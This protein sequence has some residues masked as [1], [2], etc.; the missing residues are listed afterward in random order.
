MCLQWEC[1]FLKF[2]AERVYTIEAG[3]LQSAIYSQL[4]CV[5]HSIS[6]YEL[7]KWQCRHRHQI[8]SFKYLLFKFP[9]ES[10]WV[11]TCI[12]LCIAVIHHQM[13]TRM[14]ATYM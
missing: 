5:E 6:E 1:L 13:C 4:E 12:Y 3:S 8:S 7:F 11:N 9:L 2:P 14:Q 10:L